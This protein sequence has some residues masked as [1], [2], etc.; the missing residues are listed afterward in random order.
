[1]FDLE[2]NW[3]EDSQDAA[4]EG[5]TRTYFV[6]K[7]PPFNIHPVTGTLGK[8]CVK[9]TYYCLKDLPERLCKM[10]QQTIFVVNLNVGFEIAAYGGVLGVTSE[11]V[12]DDLPAQGHVP[13]GL[14]Q[15]TPPPGLP[16]KGMVL[17]GLTRPIVA[18]DTQCMLSTQ[19]CIYKVTLAR[20][21][22]VQSS[23]MLHE[24]L[25]SLGVPHALTADTKSAMRPA[26]ERFNRKNPEITTDSKL[27]PSDL[28]VLRA[29]YGF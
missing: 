15:L 17:L 4:P 22:A 21:L 14:E 18:E 26:E 10:L 5:K 29:L 28:N 23:V 20:S 1:M 19:I 16:A 12:K 9:P 7:E 6:V 24:F 8:H 27:A 2:W 11:D 25:H 13:V 3:S